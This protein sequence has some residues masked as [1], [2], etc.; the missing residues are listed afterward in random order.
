L[1]DPTPFEPLMAS[2]FEKLGLNERIVRQLSR[3]PLGIIQPTE[4]QY[5]VLE[6]LLQGPRQTINYPDVLI[7]SETGSGKTLAYF[8]PILDHLLRIG[9]RDELHRHAGTLVMIISPRRELAVQIY[10]VIQHLLRSCVH[11]VA[12]ILIGGEKKKSEKA[13]L[14]KGVNI[15]IATPGRLLDHLKTTE[16][17]R[18]HLS[19]LRWLVLDEG[20]L[21]MDMGYEKQIREIMDHLKELD[22]SHEEKL[23][24]TENLPHQRQTIICSATLKESIK[25]L[26]YL[27]ARDP[28]FIT[29]G[30]EGID[31]D[32]TAVHPVTLASRLDR[33]R[34]FVEE[35]DDSGDEETEVSRVGV[36]KDMI[37]LDHDNE[38]YP[39]NP[40]LAT[41]PN[42]NHESYTLPKRLIQFCMVLPCKQRLRILYAFIR[43]RMREKTVI[44][45]SSCNSVDF[46]FDLFSRWVPEVKEDTVSSSKNE[47]QKKQRTETNIQRRDKVNI[48]DLG[49]SKTESPK[50]T[51]HIIDALNQYRDDREE[52][53]TFMAT[54]GGTDIPVYRLHGSMEQHER[55]RVYSE[56]VKA[57]RGI[58]ICT[59]VAAR[60]L[61]LPHVKWIIQYDPPVN[62]EE[63]IH[64]VGRTARLGRDGQAVIFLME[65][66]VEYITVLEKKTQRP[67]R[68]MEI[69]PYQTEQIQYFQFAMEEFIDSDMKCAE[70]ARSAYTAFIKAYTAHCHDEK[71]IFHH[72]KLHYGHVAKSFALKDT[73]SKV[74]QMTRTPKGD[75]SS[76]INDS[77]RNRSTPRH[78]SK[79][80]AVHFSSQSNKR[81]NSNK[82]RTR[83]D[84][85]SEFFSGHVSTSPSKTISKKRKQGNPSPIV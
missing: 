14:R 76:G 80:M 5:R 25:R 39:S 30:E 15:L 8:L 4:I 48:N 16:S 83:I 54:L 37:G 78:Q 38:A 9:T 49:S 72:R 21:L 81:C 31:D 69:E 47:M 41:I 23:L 36:S 44:F 62:I 51:R 77:F 68:R 63:Y 19:L 84:L 32:R 29:V 35:C 70:L 59:D 56:Y 20:D 12:G 24:F 67:L 73:P 11:L 26:T 3:P 85:T 60:G 66:E 33:K 34:N 18:K 50:S 42:E 45:F 55:M 28:I 58:L 74:F 71:Y 13:R 1:E 57:S 82:S 64:R 7:R 79:T 27:C 61:D 43:E 40:E 10:A 17:F 65:T 6:T 2:S 46:H 75:S 52:E 22:G 53:Q